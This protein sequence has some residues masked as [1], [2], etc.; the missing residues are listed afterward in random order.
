MDEPPRHLTDRAGTAALVETVL[1]IIM[2]DTEAAD[3]APGALPH[4]RAARALTAT[5]LIRFTPEASDGPM[6]HLSAERVYGSPHSRPGLTRTASCLQALEHNPVG[7]MY[8]PETQLKCR[9]APWMLPRQE[10][11][12]FLAA[13]RHGRRCPLLPEA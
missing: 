10:R 7:H 2:G 12:R 6:L 11:L 13:S 8:E 1:M 3:T 9:G 4:P 5:K